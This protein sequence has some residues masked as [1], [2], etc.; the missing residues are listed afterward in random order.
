MRK[1]LLYSSALGLGLSGAA[2]AACIQTPTCSSL[3]YT[4]SSACTGGVKCPFGNAWNCSASEIKTELTNK[5]TELE[6]QII[7]NQISGEVCIIG[8]IL[9]SDKSCHLNPQKGKTAIGIVVYL[10]DK[11]GGQALALKTIG[12]YNWGGY[13]PDIPELRNYE[14]K[15]EASQNYTSCE[16]SKI[17]MDNGDSSKF[18]AVWATANYST[19][20]TKVGDWCLPAAGIFASYAS[21]KDNIDQGFERAKGEKIEDTFA[22]SSTETNQA[23]GNNAWGGGNYGLTVSDRPAQKEVR[24]VIDF[25]KWINGDTG[26]GD[27]TSS[28]CN[29]GDILYSNKTCSVDIIDGKIP[30]GVVFNAE[31]KLAIGINRSNGY[32]SPSSSFSISNVTYCT[33]SNVQNDKNGKE[34]TRIISD[35]CIAN[36]KTC[37]AIKYVTTYK[38]IGTNAGEWYLPSMWELNEIYKNRSVLNTTLQKL[39]QLKLQDTSQGYSKPYFWSSSLLGWYK[40]FDTGEV[41]NNVLDVR[42]NI[43][44]VLAF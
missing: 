19:E 21:N 43:I 42:Y 12:N 10:D 31:K 37:D 7:E 8:S 6:K 27:G 11:G 9:Y 18:P 36:S 2:E 25:G 40:T 20:G 16:N 34:N 24:P 44:P 33:S 23:Y 30:I 26:E 32:L 28:V 39:G 13:G 3:G 4:S 35:A 1:F 5:I 15:E 22:W 38:T 29:I 41:K 14:T 17:I